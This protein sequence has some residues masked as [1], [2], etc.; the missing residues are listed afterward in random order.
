[1]M[2]LKQLFKNL[3]VEIKGNLGITLTSLSAHS[4]CV[5][6]GGLF[7]AK[8]GKAVDGTTFIADAVRSGAAA[9][10]TDFYNP[11][12]KG[13]TQVIT[14]DTALIE[15]IIADRYYRAPTQELFVVGVTG[16]DGKTTTSYVTQH[17]LKSEQERCGLIGT[18]E[19]DV[20]THRLPAHLTTPDLVTSQRLFR[21]MVDHKA[22]AAVMEVSSH[23]LDQQRT[24][25]IDF[26]AAVFTNLSRDH[27]DYHQTMDNYLAAKTKLFASLRDSGVAF[28]NRDDSAYE[29]IKQATEAKVI[30]YG[31][32][33]AAD[34]M[35]K[36]TDQDLTGMT[37][38]IRYQ[39]SS[40]S[41]FVP[42]IGRFNGYNVLAAVGV[43]LERGLAIATIEQRLKTLPPIP[44]RME[45]I[46]APLP[47][48][49]FVD[50]AHTPQALCQALGHL[51]KLCQ[52]KLLVVFGAGGDRDRGKRAA[53]GRA[54]ATYADTLFVTSDNP[55]SEDPKQIIADICSGVV[56]TKQVIAEPDRRLALRAA[57]Q[58]ACPGDIVLIAGRGH[59]PMQKV[60]KTSL[61]FD[62][63][64]IM[65]EELSQ[66]KPPMNMRPV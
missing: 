61:P 51:K 31:M 55:R 6:P 25:K 11:F 37:L 50:F 46:A 57:I 38:E 58:H 7:I 13:I 22:T 36:I 64:E 2:K 21:E 4:A 49:V 60:G 52:E 33:R 62:D 26:N 1:M 45:R 40:C 27:L 8:K 66:L 65:R 18:V 16:T 19:Y 17:L 39:K 44:G 41:L 9:V 5:V 56:S 32:D 30:S 29:V 20:G 54:V 63:R 53:M 42:L 47:F 28:I 3:P 15:P 48:A 43:A 24:Q 34:L 12:L 14:A 10:L 23:A 59:E 35:G